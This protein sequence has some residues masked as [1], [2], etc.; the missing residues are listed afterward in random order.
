[1]KRPLVAL[2]K[3]VGGFR[4]GSGKSGLILI[5]YVARHPDILNIR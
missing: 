1:M 3:S 2:V 5:T 4:V